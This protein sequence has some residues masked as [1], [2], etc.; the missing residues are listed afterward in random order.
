M[1]ATD[2]LNQFDDQPLS[3]TIDLPAPPNITTTSLP[4]GTVGP[5]GYNEQ[6]KHD[7]GVIYLRRGPIV[8]TAMTWSASG[9]SD[10]RG[11]RFAADVARAAVVR[12][13]AGGRC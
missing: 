4:N 10:A 13:A 2:T 8:V 3:I 6:V 12:L 9:V 11:N 7:A 1:R 5:P